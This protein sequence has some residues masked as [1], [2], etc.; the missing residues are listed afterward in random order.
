MAPRAAAGPLPAHGGCGGG[1]GG[2]GAGRVAPARLGELGRLNK[3]GKHLER[4]AEP[5]KAT[6][7]PRRRGSRGG[8]PTA[9]APGRTQRPQTPAEWPGASQTPRSLD[10]LRVRARACVCVR[11]WGVCVHLRVCVWCLF[12]PLQS[13]GFFRLCF[14]FCFL[15]GA[16]QGD[17][18]LNH[19]SL[20]SRQFN[21]KE[22]LLGSKL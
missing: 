15:R 9:N 20:I 16:M 2:G 7:S 19:L 17:E 18:C 22:A 1:S 3:Y 8:S 4:L 21:P 14:C 5:P 6:G 10:R 13:P 11:T 12:S